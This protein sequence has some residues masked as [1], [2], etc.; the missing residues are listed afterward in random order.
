M[1]LVH[2]HLGDRLR[3]D[4]RP[5]EQSVELDDRDRRRNSWEPVVTRA[6]SLSLSMSIFSLI[7]PSEKAGNMQLIASA[8]SLH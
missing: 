5:A 1:Q 4:N 3:L 6:V 2:E 8:T 7:S